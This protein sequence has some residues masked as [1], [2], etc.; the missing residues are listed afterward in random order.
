VTD[1]QRRTVSTV[2]CLTL[3]RG[4]SPSLTEIAEVL[5]VSKEAVFYRLHWLE[6]KGLW[7]KAD[8]SLTPLGLR[9]ALGL[10]G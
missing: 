1:E 3:L 5:H 7:S 4:H 10:P 8:R 6:K 9:S 2:A